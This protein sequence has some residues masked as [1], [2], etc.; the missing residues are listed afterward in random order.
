MHAQAD[1]QLDGKAARRCLGHFATG[2]AIR[3]AGRPGG[4]PD[5]RWDR[6]IAEVAFAA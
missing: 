2:V 5:L 1:R 4:K 6:R 3:F